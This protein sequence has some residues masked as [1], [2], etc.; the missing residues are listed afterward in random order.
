MGSPGVWPAHG[1]A[2]LLGLGALLLI[3]AGLLPPAAALAASRPDAEQAKIDWLLDQM[4]ASDA[5]FIRNGTEYDGKKAAA[6]MKSKL[7]WAGDRVQTARDFIAG[8]AT[9][10][11]SSGKPYLMRP[12]GSTTTSPLA[13]W[14]LARLAE[15]EKAPPAPPKKS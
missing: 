3:V 12:K 2:R 10:S 11:E 7:S 15:H 13:D 14:L 1:G 6:H 9:K 4:R 5:I 8:C